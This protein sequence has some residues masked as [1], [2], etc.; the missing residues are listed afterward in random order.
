MGYKKLNLPQGEEEFPEGLILISG[1]NSYGKSTILEGILYAFFGPKILGRKAESFITYNEN[2]AEIYVYFILDHIKYYIYRSWKRTGS[3]SS[4]LFE[5]DKNSGSYREV[6]NFNVEEFFEISQEQALSTVFIKQGE[7]EKLANKTGAELRDMIIELFRLN[8]IEDALKF[9]E[10]DSKSKSYEKST[11]EKNRVP[12]ERI[13]EDITRIKQQNEND[14]RDLL[15]KQKQK[16]Y[17][18][19][20]IKSFPSKELISELESLYKQKEISVEKYKSYKTDF[21]KKINSTDLNLEDFS[22]I[23]KISNKISSLSET[24]I[25][26]DLKKEELEKKRQAI[27]KGMGITKGKIEDIKIKIAKM[28]SSLKFTEIKGGIEIARCPTCQSELTKEHYDSMIKEF[29]KDLEINRS[30]F[31]SIS[32]VIKQQ[33]GEIK[34]IQNELDILVKEIAIIQNLK[35]DFENYQKYDFES[36]KLKKDLEAILLKNKD[37]IKEASLDAIQKKSLELERLTTELKGINKE[38]ENK[39]EEINKNQIRVTEL[40]EE[41][42]EMKKLE[43][44]IANLEID[45]EHVN[46]AREFVR[47]FVTEY[48]VVKRLVKNIALTTD[49]YIKDFTSG[50]Y[51]DLILDTSGTKKTGLS[52]KIKDNFNGQHESIEILSGGDR[53][54][55]GMALRLAI[56]ELMSIIRPTKDSPKRN[57]K[58]NFLLLDEPLAALDDVRRER[59]LKHLIRSKTFS[60]I[61][62]ITHTAIPTDIQTHKI[63]VEKDHSNGI[64]H[65]TFYK[66][67]FP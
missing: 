39:N 53:T 6:K 36:N 10:E 37:K 48:M 42:E 57:P 26:L 38:I 61:F 17:I 56:S 8:I 54:A 1:R 5:M 12:I 60:Q 3:S 18:D 65:A 49:K 45:I 29:T 66:A 16:K 30:K 43:I 50:Q 20:E 24:R 58:I 67:T 35:E 7:V 32:Q 59:I 44:E 64:S 46:K 13:N 27:T 34:T 31:E 19:K 62:L 21:E 55:L 25:E 2:K 14:E 41:I 11:R 9:L 51:S 22:S 40:L 33:D 63:V 28:Q 4:K 47:R 15:E 23:D 52:L